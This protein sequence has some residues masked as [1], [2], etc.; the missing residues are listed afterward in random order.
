MGNGDAPALYTQQGRP[1]RLFVAARLAIAVADSDPES[2]TIG[3]AMQR[4]ATVASDDRNAMCDA[5]SHVTSELPDWRSTD[6]MLS[7]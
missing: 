4:S 3:L 6:V 2:R 1:G 5:R 7:V